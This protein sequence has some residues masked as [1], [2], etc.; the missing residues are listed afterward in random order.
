MTASCFS[1]EGVVSVFYS[2]AEHHLPRGVVL[3]EPL[4]HNPLLPVRMLQSVS[5]QTALLRAGVTKLGR[6]CECR[7]MEVSE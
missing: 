5:V 7:W 1:Y 2:Q 6:P 3:Q 4:L